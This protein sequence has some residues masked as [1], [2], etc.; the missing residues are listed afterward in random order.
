V[1]VTFGYTEEPLRAADF[2]ALI[3]SFAELP[4]VATRLLSG[5]R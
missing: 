2:D 4:E 3:E 5:G 1:G